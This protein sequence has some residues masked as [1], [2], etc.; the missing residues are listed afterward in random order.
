MSVR[1]YGR[2]ESVQRLKNH[3][4]NSNSSTAFEDDSDKSSTALIDTAH[5]KNSQQT[6]RHGIGNTVEDTDAKKEVK[7]IYIFA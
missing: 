6:D 7:C 1:K 5:R 3:D 2:N 4:D